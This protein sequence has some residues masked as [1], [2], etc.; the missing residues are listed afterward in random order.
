MAY[1]DSHCQYMTID[2]ID[3][4]LAEGQKLVSAMFVTPYPPGFPILVPGQ[5]VTQ[6]II[7]FMRALDTR[8]IHGY[9]AELGFRLFQPSVL[10]S[11]LPSPQEAS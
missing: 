3:A 1:K 4:A 10:Q 8:E 2:R 6:P 7:D 5:V 9:R 11:C